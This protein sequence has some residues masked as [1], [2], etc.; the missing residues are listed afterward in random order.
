MGLVLLQLFRPLFSQM[1]DINFVIDNFLGPPENPS[2]ILTEN[3]FQF[4][5]PMVSYD[6][7]I[8]GPSNIKCPNELIASDFAKKMATRAIR[9]GIFSRITDGLD[10]YYNFFEQLY[11]GDGGS[12]LY[13]WVVSS[14]S[15]PKIG[16]ESGFYSDEFR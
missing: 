9:L 14:L 13:G 12:F 2:T 5:I 6:G 16:L 15:E 7:K 1:G 3:Q 10:I 11:K 4:G 8:L